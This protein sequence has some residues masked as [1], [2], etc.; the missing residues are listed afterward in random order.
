MKNV[1]TITTALLVSLVAVSQARPAD[2]VVIELAKT[3]KVVFTMK[4]RSDLETLKQY[5]FQAL[6]ND[7]LAKL[8]AKDTVRAGLMDTTK[9]TNSN[10]VVQTETVEENWGKE[11]END[12]DNW[13]HKKYRH[14]GTRHSFNFDFGMNNYLEEGKFPDQNGSQYAI[15]PWGSWYIGMNST[16]RTQVSNKFFIEWGTGVSWYNF[17]FQDDNT[18]MLQDANGVYFDTDA[19]TVSF[20]KS[21]LMVC[22]LNASIVPMFDLGGHSRRSRFWD[23]HGSSFRIGVGPY[24]GYRIDSSHKLVYKEDGDKEKDKDKDDFYINNMRYGL[25]AQLGVRSVDFFF[26]YDFNELFVENK[27]PKLNAFSFGVIF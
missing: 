20:K 11:D 25:R 24:V 3:S 5:D 10:T 6:F 12:D 19:R 18:L 22:Y 23:S 1:L 4:D 16:L 26:N 17:K 8:E 21:R 15:R 27:G 9:T 2:T 7:L 13:E 14:H